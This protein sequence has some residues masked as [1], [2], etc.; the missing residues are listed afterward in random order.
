MEYS[1]TY[2]KISLKD[3][4]V[5]VDWLSEYVND[6]HIIENAIQKRLEIQGDKFYPMISDISKLKGGNNKIRNRL[7]QPDGF[8]GVSALSVICSTKYQIAQFNYFNLKHYLPM[9]SSLFTTKEAALHWIRS[10]ETFKAN[11]TSFYPIPEHKEQYFKNDFYELKIHDGIF[12]VD[13]LMEKYTEKP[14]DFIIRKKVEMCN[15]NFYPMFTDLSK[16]RYVTRGSMR[17]MA[18]DDAFI[19]VKASATL[20]KSNVQKTLYKMYCAIYK[21]K[22]PN[23]FFTDKEAALKWLYKFRTTFN[24]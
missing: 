14:I 21:P 7:I 3:G 6:I 19:G 20:C 4:I 17:R 8:K 13:W 23:R 11:E 1:D 5:Y 22:A 12:Y 2:F 18:E 9:P 10:F 24:S 16:I 15:G